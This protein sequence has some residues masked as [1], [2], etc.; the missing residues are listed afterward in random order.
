MTMVLFRKRYRAEY[1]SAAW[2]YSAVRKTVN[3][4]YALMISVTVPGSVSPRGLLCTQHA[5]R[6]DDEISVKILADRIER[7]V[8]APSPL[9]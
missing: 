7:T 2:A 6:F 5:F 4:L 9:S 1:R 8:Y 3:S